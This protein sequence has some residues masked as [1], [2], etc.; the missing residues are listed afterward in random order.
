MWYPKL[1]VGYHRDILMTCSQTSVVI[2][3]VSSE[4]LF[5]K[6]VGLLFELL[7]LTV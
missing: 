7:L 1:V 3:N 2:V 4:S 5:C 6:D